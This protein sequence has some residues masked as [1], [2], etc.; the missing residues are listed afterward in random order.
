MNDA[1]WAERIAAALA[2]DEHAW[3]A[4]IDK[5]RPFLRRLAARELPLR[6]QS[7]VDPSDIVQESLLEAWDARATFLGSS[8]PQLKAWLCSI[9]QHNVQDLIRR[10]VKAGK[11]AVG[12]E[13]SLDE[14][15]SSGPRQPKAIVADEL[16]PRARLIRRESLDR[17]AGSL[18]NLPSRQR[19]AVQL[20]YFERC[21]LAQL[22]GRLKLTENAAAQLLHRAV[23]KIRRQYQDPG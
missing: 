17:L 7:R 13:R 1:L 19:E 22:A 10:H 18:E 20:W 4:V 14:L 11:R 5:L 21:S 23:T 2:G 15:R 6:L 16:S 9:L 3:S 12:E 8:E